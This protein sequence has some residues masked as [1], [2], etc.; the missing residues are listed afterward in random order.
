M[1]VLARDPEATAAT[2]ERWFTSQGY[3]DVRVA[4]LVIP[5]A[6]GWSNETILFDAHWVRDGVAEDQG[7]VARVAPSDY[8]VF[9]DETFE[10]QFHILGAVGRSGAAPVPGVLG[11]DLDPSWFGKPF[12]IMERIDGEIAADNPPYASE[13]WL[14][15]ATHEQQRAAWT[16]AIDAMA[17]IHNLDVRSLDWPADTL[18]IPN[19]LLEARFAHYEHFLTW[20]EEGK[21]HPLCRRA[22]AELRATRPPEPARGPALSW[23]DSRFS[24]LIFRDFEVVAVLDWEMAAIGDP[25]LD[26]GWWIFADDAMTVG[27]GATRLPGFP[28]IA[29]TADQ[30]SFA[31]DRSAEALDWYVKLAGLHFSIIMLR[32]GKLLCDMG[33]VPPEFA[34]DN[35]ISQ[36][37]EAHLAG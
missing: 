12:W 17:A 28:S 37:F 36:R 16:S 29:E 5:S 33:L 19:D 18:E 31:T 9:P 25:L 14:A 27:T 23:G 32:M 2:L 1:G 15:E 34:Y 6:T 20:A 30:W 13:G 22:L 3:D 10:R 7:L 11:I 24:N 21:E 8:Q 4:N 26:L 35:L